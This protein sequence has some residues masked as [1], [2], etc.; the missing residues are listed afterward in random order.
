[1]DMIRLWQSASKR[2]T[3]PG[4]GGKQT[5]KQMKEGYLYHNTGAPLWR[6][7]RIS[8]SWRGHTAYTQDEASREGGREC[9]CVVAVVATGFGGG[10]RGR[11]G[12]LACRD[13]MSFAI[14]IGGL[15]SRG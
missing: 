2:V 15:C 13:I 5:R 3:V 1:M 4:W 12:G 11:R 10:D 14:E 8:I 7:D 6:K 9:G